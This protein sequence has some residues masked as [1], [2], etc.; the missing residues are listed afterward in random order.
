V[1]LYSA[2][3]APNPRRV[4]IFLTEKGLSKVEI[5][6]I[7]MV[8]LQHKKKAYLQKNPLGL[9]PTLELD[10]GRTITESMAICEYLEELYPEPTLFGYEAWQRALTREASRIVEFGLLLGA[11][12]SFQHSSSFFKGRWEQLPQN[13]TQGQKHFARYLERIDDILA[14]RK[15]LAGDIFTVADIAGI[16][17]ID[18]GK[19]CGC[20]IKPNLKH[21]MRWLDQVRERP[22]C[23]LGSKRS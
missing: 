9:L 11:A 16:C 20:H 3:F 7:D 21:F 15:W 23:Q 13:V 22:S 1:K 12:K 14:D 19:T 5:V 18:F 6:R 10:D 4:E 17:A 2:K 8:A